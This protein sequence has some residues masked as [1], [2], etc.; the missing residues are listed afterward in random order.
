MANGSN[1]TFQEL[2]V[3]KYCHQK[4]AHCEKK[5]GIL[6]YQCGNDACRRA[7]TALPRDQDTSTSAFC[8]V[9]ICFLFLLVLAAVGT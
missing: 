4:T 5:D 6:Y 3:C 8:G 7:W 1:F 2:M 9:L